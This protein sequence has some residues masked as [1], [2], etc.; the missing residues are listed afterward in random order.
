MM[1]GLTRILL[2]SNKGHKELLQLAQWSP[3]KSGKIWF[4][5]AFGTFFIPLMR[6]TAAILLN[7]LETP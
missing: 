2:Q 1:S 7:S 6:D 5:F 4:Q 3:V